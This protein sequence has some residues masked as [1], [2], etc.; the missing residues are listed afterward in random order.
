MARPGPLSGTQTDAS[1]PPPPPSLPPPLCALCVLSRF[2]VVVTT[3]C[4]PP[5]DVA[6]R[7]MGKD[8]IDSSSTAAGRVQHKSIFSNI[9]TLD[10]NNDN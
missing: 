7:I 2:F 10:N 4:F 5:R 9:G 1:P 3:G 6:R 8:D